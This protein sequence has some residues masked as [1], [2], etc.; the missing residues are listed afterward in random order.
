MHALTPGSWYLMFVCTSCKTRQVL[1]PDLSGGRSKIKA[2]YWVTCSKCGHGG[3][4]DSDHIERYQ[5]VE[6]DRQAVA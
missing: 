1:F 2:T 4:Y 5:H 6:E 3:S